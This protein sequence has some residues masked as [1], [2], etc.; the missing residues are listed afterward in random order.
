MFAFLLMTVAM[1]DD[2]DRLEGTALAEAARSS[3][4]KPCESLTFSDLGSLP[5]AL[6]DSRSALLVIKTS[7]GNTARML[8]TPAYRK[9]PGGGEPFPILLVE[10]METFEAGP[11]TRRIAR[12][13][14]LVLFDGFFL[15]LDTGQVVPKGQG[16]DL[17]FTIKPPEGPRLQAVGALKILTFASP[18]LSTDEAKTK[19]SSGRAIRVSDF[20]GRYRIFANGQTSGILMLNVDD[21]GAASGRMSSD[22]TGGSY[23]ITGRVVEGAPNRIQFAAELPRTRLEFDGLLFS[24]GKGAITGTY[25]MLNQ[26][27]GFFAIRDNAHLSPDGDDLYVLRDEEDRPGKLAVEIRKDDVSVDGKPMDSAAMVI[28]IKE[29]VNRDPRAWVA[30]TVPEGIVWGRL[31]DIVDAIRTANPDRLR[32]VSPKK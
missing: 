12:V 7:E 17:V 16:E 10:R 9:P 22:Q 2:F 1:L 27:F 18:P 14:E 3:L 31:R 5:H 4:A 32:I 11:L 26:S 20:A 28:A 8:V 30:L 23:P 13:R 24:D 6:K 29:N 19:P 25:A 21:A 15:D